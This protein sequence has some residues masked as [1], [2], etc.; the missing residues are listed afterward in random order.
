V[1]APFP[2]G[3]LRGAG[4]A[5]WV[6]CAL[7]GCGEPCP[8]GSMLDSAGGL[9]AVEQEHPEAWG[10]GESCTSCHAIPAL[11]RQACT[12]GVDGPALRALVA[13]EGE[14]SCRGC[15]GALGVEE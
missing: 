1:S 11:H 10:E 7:S 12:D 2:W 5:L 14:D 3:A 6:G 13:D 4:L 15:H 8:D 9:V